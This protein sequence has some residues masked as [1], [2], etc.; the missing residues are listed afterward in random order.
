[1]L[2]IFL[3]SIFL[4]FM[5]RSFFSLVCLSFSHFLCYL[6]SFSPF[7]SIPFRM[8]NPQSSSCKAIKLT[9]YSHLC[10]FLL[11]H[12]GCLCF[13]F[14][15]YKVSSHCLRFSICNSTTVCLLLRSF[16]LRFSSRNVSPSFQNKVHFLF[17]FASQE[18]SFENLLYLIKNFH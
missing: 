7:V 16:E 1:M 12:F 9:I 15:Y 4:P 6:S 11:C 5:L 10:I 3:S 18:V 13:S 2:C 17:L 8:L 14:S